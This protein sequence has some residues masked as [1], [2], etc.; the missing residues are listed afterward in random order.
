[1]YS[2][3]AEGIPQR[4]EEGLEG[5]SGATGNLIEVAPEAL[6]PSI[7]SFCVMGS[8]NFNFCA[9]AALLPGVPVALVDGHGFREARPMEALHPGA[10]FVC[11]WVAVSD[12]FTVR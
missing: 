10:G 8:D 5:R 12:V 4:W 9:P 1:M 11:C 2:A 7:L 6:L 3:L